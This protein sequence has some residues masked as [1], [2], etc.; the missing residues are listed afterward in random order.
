MDDKLTPME[1]EVLEM[2]DPAAQESPDSYGTGCKPAPKRNYVGF[3]ICVGLAVI[4]V[5]TFGIVAAVNHLHLSRES[6][7]W[8]LSVQSPSEPSAVQNPVNNLQLSGPDETAAADPELSRGG[9]LGLSLKQGAVGP[10]L[11]ASA[12]YTKVKDGV[13]CLSCQTYYGTLYTTGVVISQNGY[14]LTALSS[15]RETAALKATFSDGSEYTARKIGEDRTTGLCILKIEASGL[16]ALT[17]SASELPDVGSTVYWISNPYG[18]A[19]PNVFSAGMLAAKQSVNVEGTKRT[20]IKLSGDV[21]SAGYGCPVF[22]AHGSIIGL[23]TPIGTA[24]LSGSGDPCFAVS[25]RDLQAVVR[26]LNTG[27]R[28]GNLWLGF[29][30]EQIPEEYRFM[31]G[32]PEGVWLSEVGKGTRVD[33]VLYPYDIILTVDGKEVTGVEEFYAALKGKTPGQTVPITLY[34]NGKRYYAEIPVLKR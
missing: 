5:C 1:A 21:Q 24:F 29:E 28:T 12:L 6:G 7:T 3:W 14:I 10:E 26:E 19:V 34:R 15:Q 2:P 32:Y 16:T 31:F 33:G 27:D 30:V 8:R 25:A 22:D 11:T 20:V 17:F 4:G 18:P 13:V 9:D 23:T